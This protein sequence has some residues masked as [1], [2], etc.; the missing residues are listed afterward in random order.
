MSA[1][2]FIVPHDYTSVGDAALKYALFLAKPRKTSIM[3]L[4]IVSNK[5][6]EK[7]ALEKLEKIIENL[8]L[9]VGDGTVQASVAEGN[10]FDDISKI[11]EKNDA[12]LIIMGTHGASGMQKLF[13]SY[14]MKVVSNSSIPFLVVQDGVNQSKLNNIVIP[15][16]TSK[17][18]LQIVHIAG[19]IAKTFESK[20]YVIAEFQSDERLA[21]QL[22]IRISLLKNQ[23]EE[24]GVEAEIEILKTKKSF[25][26]SIIDFAKSK[27]CDLIAVA[28]HSSSIFAQFEKYTQ[29]LIT[30]DEYFPCLVVNAKLLSK[31]YY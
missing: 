4:H 14:A 15:I 3:L 19:E 30:N 18:S 17:E 25:Q 24:K 1:N 16:T 9:G 13:G 12:R 28:H 26:K 7:L 29:D 22:K 8:D 10:I 6:K 31:P 27:N 2:L 21:H 5:D 20:I 11:A 23:F